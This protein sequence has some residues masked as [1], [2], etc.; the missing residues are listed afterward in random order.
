MAVE[1]IDTIK[2]KNGGDFPIV[3]AEDV[4]YEGKRL[5]EFLPVCLTQDEYDALV[6]AGTVNENT[7]YLIKE[8]PA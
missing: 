3:E 2:P 1:V 6:A 8:D 4:A 5:P 7:W